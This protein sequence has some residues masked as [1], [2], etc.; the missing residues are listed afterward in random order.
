MIKVTLQLRLFKKSLQ[1][2][3]KAKYMSTQGSG[4]KSMS[5]IKHTAVSWN[6]NASGCRLFFF[7]NRI[8][9]DI[10]SSTSP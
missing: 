1:T 8:P 5:D 3:F 7:L 9:E 4:V 6:G 2:K 10:D